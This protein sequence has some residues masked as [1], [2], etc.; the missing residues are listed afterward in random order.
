MPAKIYLE[1]VE[2]VSQLNKMRLPRWVILEI[3]SKIA[4]ERA[5]VTDDDPPTAVG[6][7]TWRW[8][9]R[10]CRE[11]K[12][13]KELGWRACERD[14]I[15]GL[16][17]DRVRI[18]LVICST[19]ANTGSKRTPKS[20]SEKGPAGCRLVS[21]NSAQ[22]SFPFIDDRED[23]YDLW[24]LC[25]YFC[26]RHITAEVS[27]PTSEVAG[28]VTDFSDRIIVAGPDEIPGIRRLAPVLREFADVPKPKVTRKS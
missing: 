24:Y 12:K 14:Q 7:E 17:N 11:D 2:V 23:N 1:E 19:D 4:G 25:V 10:F 28:I 27:R 21:K 18:K 15:S 9:T 8:G 13:L 26:E 22:A 5:N 3:I 16:K 6:Y 20:L